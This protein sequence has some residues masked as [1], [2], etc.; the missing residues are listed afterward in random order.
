MR[1]TRRRA[2]IGI[3][4]N[5]ADLDAATSRLR[6]KG[7][8]HWEWFTVTPGSPATGQGGGHPPLST[9]ML[10]DLRA[11]YPT[12]LVLRVDLTGGAAEET[13]VA[14][15]LLESAAQSVRLHDL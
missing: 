7:I 8:R 15:T 10:G 2:A 13:L 9:S 6:S 1:E 14:Q 11:R 4:A 3:F 12:A 5:T